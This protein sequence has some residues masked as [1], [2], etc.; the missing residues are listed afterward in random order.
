M[1]LRGITIIF[2]KVEKSSYFSYLYSLPL[3]LYKWAKGKNNKY[4]Q[5]IKAQLFIGDSSNPI[6]IVLNDI[7]N[8]LNNTILKLDKNYKIYQAILCTYIDPNIRFITLDIMGRHIFI[9]FSE[10]NDVDYVTKLLFGY[11]SLYNPLYDV[12]INET[13]S[14]ID[15]TVTKLELTTYSINCYSAD[16]N[17]AITL[18]TCKLTQ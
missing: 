6:S 1:I 16:Y 5:E 15:G 17:E 4:D 7:S 8:S 18:H 13:T 12:I 3:S 9:N 14:K 10:D 2:N 11:K